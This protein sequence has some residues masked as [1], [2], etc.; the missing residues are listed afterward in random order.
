MGTR[1][2]LEK[3]LSRAVELQFSAARARGPE[4]GNAGQHPWGPALPWVWA[5]CACPR[6]SLPFY[7]C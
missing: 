6:F 2:L 1:K 4:Q 7:P 5:P 3:K